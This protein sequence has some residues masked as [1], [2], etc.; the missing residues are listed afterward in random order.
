MRTQK[1][2]S[3]MNG[4]GVSNV[5]VEVAPRV[6]AGRRAF[7]LAL[8][9]VAY[10]FCYVDRMVMSTTIPYIGRELHLSKTAMGMVMSAFFLG[11]TAFQIPGGI[12]V[13]KYGPRLIMTIAFTVWSIFTGVT[14]MIS[15]LVQLL[16]ARVLFGIG[17][18]P[19]PAASMKSIALWFDQS[20]RATA[21]SIILSSNA[22]GP[23]IAPLLAVAIMAHWG[24]RAT[25][26]SLV[27]PGIVVAVLIAV[28]VTDDPFAKEKRRDSSQAVRKA[29]QTAQYSF[30]QVLKEPTVWKATVMF[31]FANIAGWGFK[32]W[33]PGYLVIARHMD[34]KT[35]GV[36]ASIPFFAGIV[37]YL[38]GGWLSDGRFKNNRKIPV[39][40]FQLVTALLFYLMF[41]VESM[42]ML[43]IFQ[44]L[45]GFFLSAMLA[46]TWAL[47]VSAVS[48]KITGRAVG[49]F[50]TGGQL[51]GL[52]SPTIIGYLVD[53]S[54]GS[55]N[56][57]F[58]FMI[59]CLIIASAI[60]LTLGTNVTQVE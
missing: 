26:Y 56:S 4:Q 13:D 48:K 55:F 50:N 2:E 25:F 20:K 53:V 28:F 7:V 36:A 39:I 3:G 38:F 32:S 46:A 9:F 33:L 41:T 14:G 45:A 19:F 49:I 6:N 15:N 42:S 51:A 21:T 37:G 1:G 30:W 16:L 24:W 47:P 8:I 57:S 18:G 44:T 59:S 23:A 34:M 10:L 29:P 12:L 22:L 27:V 40:I 35:M 58:I 54:K 31:F 43:M 17:E 60:T 11:Y 5:E 52:I